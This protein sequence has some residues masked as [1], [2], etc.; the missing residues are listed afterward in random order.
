MAAIAEGTIIGPV[1]EVLV[2][3]TL[4]GY[5]IEVAIPPVASPMNTSYVV[6]SRET[7]RFVNEI[8][9]TNT[10][11]GPVANCSQTF[12]DQKE[13]NY[14]KKKGTSS[15]KE[16]CANTPAFLLHK[17]PSTQKG[18]YLRTKGNG[19]LFMH[20]DKTEDTWQL[21]SPNWLQKW[22]V[23][24]TKMNDNLMVQCIGTQL[25]QYC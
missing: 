25:G 9:I 2:V 11:S 12:K 5:G 21:Q 20:I 23:I 19:R 8:L 10:S 4:D 1:L 22:C 14:M 17:R 18:P 16:I 7:D 13:V 15:I 24:M 3:K 6:T